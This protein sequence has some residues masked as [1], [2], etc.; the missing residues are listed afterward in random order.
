MATAYYFCPENDIALARYAQGTAFTPPRRALLLA[1]YG[2]PLMWWLG[3]SDDVVLVP[4][5][6]TEAERHALRQWQ[7]EMVRRFGAGP[8]LVTSLSDANVDR[9]QPWGWSRYTIHRLRDAGAPEHL[10]SEVEARIDEIRTI[11]HRRSSIAIT[12]A[13]RRAVDFEKY[14]VECAELPEKCDTMSDVDH[15]I[16]AG[17]GLYAKSPWSSSGRGVVCSLDVPLAGFR[18]RCEESIRMQGSVMIEPAYKR[19]VDFAMLYM[20]EQGRFTPFGLSMFHNVRGAMYAGNLIASNEGMLHRLGGYVPEG[21]LLSIQAALSEVLHDVVG[22]AYNG[23]LGVDMLVADGNDGR[24]VVAPCVEL[25]L[26]CTMG[27]VAHALSE[28]TCGY[29]RMDIAAGNLPVSTDSEVLPLVPLNPWFSIAA[30]V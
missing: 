5:D 3:N 30:R 7:A 18:R 14:G 20:A 6:L 29:T 12:A 24:C 2:A 8:E 21:L 25:N 26:R 23:P 13:V 9:L 19:L 16:A 10:L 1:R 15:R 28:K 27:F 11:S 4:H 22:T 17:S